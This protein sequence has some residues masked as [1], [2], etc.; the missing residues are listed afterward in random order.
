MIE[1]FYAI[2]GIIVGF[3]MGVFAMAMLITASRYDDSSSIGVPTD[4]PE[5]DED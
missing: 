3:A 4:D 5:I 1:S 2:G